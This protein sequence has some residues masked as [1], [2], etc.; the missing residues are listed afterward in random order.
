MEMIPVKPELKAQLDAYAR[1]HGQSTAD[2]LNDLLLAQ[3]NAE[4]QGPEL[5]QEEWVRKLKAWGEGNAGKNLTILPDEALR[6]E[7]MYE[8]RGL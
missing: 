1:Q 3:L 7:N 5:S 8:D 4:P 6:R 2:A